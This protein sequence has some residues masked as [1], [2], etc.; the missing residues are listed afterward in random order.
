MFAS[1]RVDALRQQCRTGCNKMVDTFAAGAVH[2]TGQTTIAAWGQYIAVLRKV[3][4]V[5]LGNQYGIYGTAAAVQVFAMKSVREHKTH[6]RDGLKVLPLVDGKPVGDGDTLRQHFV[7]KGDLFIVHK[8]SALLD[9][10]VAVRAGEDHPDD[11]GANVEYVLSELLDMRIPEAGWPDYKKH[12]DHQGSDPHATAVALLSISRC[13]RGTRAAEACREALIWIKDYPLEQQSI[14]TISLVVAATNALSDVIKDSKDLTAYQKQTEMALEAW[15]R[16]TSPVEI[17]R[18]LAATEHWQPEEATRDRTPSASR[19]D[20]LIYLP[21]CLAALAVLSSDRLRGSGSCRRFVLGTVER[22]SDGTTTHGHFV[23]AG[24]S[25]VS[26]VEHL[27]LYRLLQEFDQQDLYKSKRERLQDLVAEGRWGRALAIAAVLVTFA[28]VV[29]S[30]T[31]NG[32][33]QA[34][35]MGLLLLI[36][37]VV[38]TV[39]N[40]QLAAKS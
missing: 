11:V 24:R 16:A 29:V 31:T 14:I 23:A 7:E 35:S 20:F 12:G 28:L 32:V 25:L 34:V 19:F 13:V 8:V 2:P 39:L 37:G 10:A 5:D 26:A 30:A 4:E 3:P 17:Q 40:N 6:I 1:K 33:V 27:W 18:S 22:V 15:I 38:S 9:A 21:H 36:T